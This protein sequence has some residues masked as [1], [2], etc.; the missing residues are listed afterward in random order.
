MS[1]D[2]AGHMSQDPAGPRPGPEAEQ[3]IMRK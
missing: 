1:Q 3:K 2:P